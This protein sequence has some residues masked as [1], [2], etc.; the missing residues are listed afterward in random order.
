MAVNRAAAGLRLYVS[1]PGDVD[2]RPLLDG[3]RRRGAQPYVLSDVAPPGAAVLD[4]LRLAI[5]AAGRVLVVLGDPPAPDPVFQ[6]GLALG[7]G[8]PLLIIAAPGVIVPAG[9]TGQ[10]VARAR[11]GDLDAINFTLDHLRPGALEHTRRAPRRADAL[12]GPA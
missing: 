12:W 11:P 2:L 1:A 3:L 8:K 4:S 6:A 9:L 7:P 5:Q 10:V